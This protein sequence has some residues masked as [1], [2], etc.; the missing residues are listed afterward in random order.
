M[1]TT[2]ERVIAAATPDPNENLIQ[3][4]NRLKRKRDNLIKTIVS[5]LFE[6]NDE[7]KGVMDQQTRLLAE[8][9]PAHYLAMESA[10]EMIDRLI[11]ELDQKKSWMNDAVLTVVTGCSG[12]DGVAHVVLNNPKLKKRWQ[13]VR[14]A[15]L[16]SNRAAIAVLAYRIGDPATMNLGDIVNAQGIHY[17]QIVI[18]YFSGSPCTAI[19]RANLTARG[20][21]SQWTWLQIESIRHARRCGARIIVLENSD[22]LLN[23]KRYRPWLNAVLATFRRWGY[24]ARARV[25]CPSHLGHPNRRKRTYL[26]G[27]WTGELPID[28]IISEPLAGEVLDRENDEA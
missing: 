9:E 26:V 19:S 5:A 22:E 11:K 23:N 24:T 10:N 13:L 2:N 27:V 20:A 4:F 6:L 18:L 25:I 14:Y 17:P 1:T 15:E 28:R 16:P 12:Y 3:A 8:S 7:W 21:A